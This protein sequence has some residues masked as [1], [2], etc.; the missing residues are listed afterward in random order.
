MPKKRKTHDDLLLRIRERF[1]QATDAWAD[2][3]KAGAEDMRHVAGNPWPSDDKSK[4]RAAGRPALALDELGQYFNQVIND[5]RANPRGVKFAATGNGAND[6][7][8]KFYSEK[9][10]EI[11]Y[12]SNAQVAYTTAFENAVQRGYGFC[13]VNTEVKSFRSRDQEIIIEPF[14]NPA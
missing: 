6:E 1:Q 7:S 14:P 3:R 5:V 11:E 13:R 8:A 12:R 2:I 9:M 10:R 4:R